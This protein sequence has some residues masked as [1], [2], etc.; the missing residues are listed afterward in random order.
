MNLTQR[1]PKARPYSRFAILAVVDQ[2][3]VEEFGQPSHLLSKAKAWI[4]TLRT[5]EKRRQTKV[6]DS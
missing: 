5:N 4:E 1:R 3:L 2:R 6:Q